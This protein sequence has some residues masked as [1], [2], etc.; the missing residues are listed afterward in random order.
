MTKPDAGQFEQSVSRL[1]CV[2]TRRLV[3]NDRVVLEGDDHRQ[4]M[5]NR[6]CDNLRLCMWK[7]HRVILERDN[8]CH[9][10]A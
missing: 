10:M 3:E 6:C 1:R 2:E 4:F 9:F 5:A 7:F 8:H